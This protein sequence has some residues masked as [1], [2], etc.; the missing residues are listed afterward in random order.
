MKF[1]PTVVFEFDG[2][3]CDDSPSWRGWN[4]ID[5]KLIPGIGDVIQHFR[6]CG[7]KVVVQ[8]IRCQ[9]TAGKDA[10]ANFLELH[11]IEV[12]E[13]TGE[14]VS[15]I[16]TIDKNGI[17]FVC[18]PERLTNV[19]SG[20][21]PWWKNAFTTAPKMPRLRRCTIQLDYKEKI[22]LWKV[23]STSGALITRSL[24]QVP[25]RSRLESWNSMTEV[26]FRELRVRLNSSMGDGD[27][28]RYYATYKRILCSRIIRYGNPRSN[29]RSFSG[30]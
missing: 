15:A 2:T 4:V 3:I 19:V 23:I 9:C 8:S 25:V 10:V 22:L 27:M 7:Y 13:I 29:C 21:E 12:D 11:R 26:W 14:S 16:A 6:E 5:G 28:A 20:I 30:V 24:K 17:R 18:E 1:T